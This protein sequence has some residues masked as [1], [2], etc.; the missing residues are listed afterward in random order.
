MEEM[1]SL[2]LDQLKW[3]DLV[4]SSLN[5]RQEQNGRTYHKALGRACRTTGQYCQTLIHLLSVK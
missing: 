2:D 1:R 4:E 5:I 3:N